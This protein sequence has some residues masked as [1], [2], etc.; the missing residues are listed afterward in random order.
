MLATAVKPKQFQTPWLV[1]LIVLSGI[2]C[3][4]FAGAS[5]GVSSR[6]TFNGAWVWSWTLSLIH[7]TFAL[8][9]SRSYPT[10]AGRIGIGIGIL[11]SVIG[12]LAT[13][14]EYV[15]NFRDLPWTAVYALTALSLASFASRQKIVGIAGLALIAL[16]ILP[17]RAK[18]D[19]A[20]RNI[21]VGNLIF[22]AA[23]R[24]SDG[25]RY[26]LRSADGSDIRQA[27]DWE[28]VE[29]EGKAG[30][31]LP[32]RP[33]VGYS[34]HLHGKDRSVFELHIH[35]PMATWM[36]SWDAKMK[37]YKWPIKSQGEFQI[38]VAGIAKAISTEAG[39]ASFILRS[40][41]VRKESP[42]SA[43]ESALDLRIEYKAGGSDYYVR[44]IDDMGTHYDIAWNYIYTDG[45]SHLDAWS[46]TPIPVRPI[47]VQ[48]NE[49]D[50]MEE[51]ELVFD[52]PN[53]PF[54]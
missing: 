30:P 7:F 34:E 13:T 47:R 26:I 21:Q 8:I 9:F 32:V 39:P 36:R 31:L 20:N 40:A 22:V 15:D 4:M 51:G 41:R 14:V 24:D 43:K 54:S 42:E 10:L 45:R 48:I 29:L 11:F 28:R 37:I 49:H 25:Y 19:Q 2:L 50:C 52:L 5:Y 17:A 35:A 46:I 18:A 3:A 33:R 16:L 23:I 38:P 27:Y 53:V 6:P 1:V 12:W 44:A